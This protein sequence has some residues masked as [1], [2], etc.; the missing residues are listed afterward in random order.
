MPQEFEIPDFLPQY[1]HWLSGFFFPE[2]FTT[3]RNMIINF[4]CTPTEFG[5]LWILK[6]VFGPSKL[7]V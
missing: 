2:I 5:E 1:W 7:V 6:V 3:L 4:F